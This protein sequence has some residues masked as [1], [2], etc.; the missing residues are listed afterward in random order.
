VCLFMK[1]ISGSL[2]GKTEVIAK[3]TGKG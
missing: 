1:Q 3:L 2:G